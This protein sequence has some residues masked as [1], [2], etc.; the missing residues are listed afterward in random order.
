MAARKRRPPRRS[1]VVISSPLATA[2]SKELQSVRSAVSCRNCLQCIGQAWEAV[3]RLLQIRHLQVLPLHGK[4]R[5]VVLRGMPV[6]SKSPP[7]Q[8]ND[9]CSWGRCLT[10]CRCQVPAL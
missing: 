2:S 3:R 10:V 1:A 4:G 9:R 6:H 5:G 8:S 7:S